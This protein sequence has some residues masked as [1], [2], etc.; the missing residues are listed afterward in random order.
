MEKWGVPKRPARDEG[1]LLPRKGGKKKQP[2]EKRENGIM[3]WW[4]GWERTLASALMENLPV[5]WMDRR[6]NRTHKCALG[7]SPGC[8]INLGGV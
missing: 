6:T 1:L 2:K 4:S 7:M 8:F 3:G 5:G